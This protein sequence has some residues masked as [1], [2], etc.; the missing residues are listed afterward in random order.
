MILTIYDDE[1]EAEIL[2]KH[3]K[4]YMTRYKKYRG[5]VKFFMFACP[6]VKKSFEAWLPCNCPYCGQWLGSLGELKTENDYSPRQKT[7]WFIGVK[8]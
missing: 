6:V 5:K 3:V 2:V 1:L 7:I 8:C 4:V